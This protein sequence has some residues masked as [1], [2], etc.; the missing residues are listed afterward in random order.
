MIEGPSS[1]LS[2]APRLAE[3]SSI[4]GPA[5]FAGRHVS[6]L[7]ALLAYGVPTDCA[8]AL[9]AKAKADSAREL[10]IQL[11]AE[12]GGGHCTLIVRRMRGNHA[13]AWIATSTAAA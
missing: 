4:A 8:E 3:P 13:E 9:I 12:G 6:M 10:R 11:I 1:P 7:R 2:P 5:R